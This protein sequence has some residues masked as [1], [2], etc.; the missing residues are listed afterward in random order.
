MEGAEPFRFEGNEIGVLTSH[1]FTGTRQSVHS[2]GEALA[3]ED[4]TVMGT[5][6]EGHG[7][8]IEDTSPG[9]PSLIGSPLSKRASPGCSSALVRSSS[10]GLDGRYFAAK[11]PGRIRGSVP[12]N[13]CLSLNNPDL[14]RVVFDPEAQRPCWMSARI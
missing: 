9:A 3:E 4:F 8:S 13:A 5:R 10:W 7:T 14:T 1:G 11:H 12:I 6:L 2:L